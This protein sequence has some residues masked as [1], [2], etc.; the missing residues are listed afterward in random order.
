MAFWFD[1][2][3]NGS[4]EEAPVLVVIGVTEDGHKLVLGL[5]AG[6]KESASYLA[7]ILQ[8]SQEAWFTDEQGHFRGYG[9]T[10]SA[11]KCLQRGIG[12]LC[13]NLTKIFALRKK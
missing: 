11:G 10:D 4:V 9:R 12:K 1:M 7:R 6:D 13:S 3:V 5:Q 8:G 2:R